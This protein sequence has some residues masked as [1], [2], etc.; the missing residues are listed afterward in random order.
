MAISGSAA[1]TSVALVALQKAESLFEG[2]ELDESVLHDALLSAAATAAHER[3]QPSPR[4]WGV[5]GEWSEVPAGE[6]PIMATYLGPMALAT[7]SAS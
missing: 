5:F 7:T 1:E 6:A 2:D 3:R 4:Q